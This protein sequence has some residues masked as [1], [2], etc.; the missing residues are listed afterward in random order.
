[1]TILG[2]QTR[3]GDLGQNP[4]LRAAAGDGAAAAPGGHRDEP[5][6]GR[7]AAGVVDVHPLPHRDRPE[8]PPARERSDPSG[9]VRRDRDR[10]GRA[11]P[12][13]P[14]G[15]PARL[16]A[17]PSAMRC[18]TRTRSTSAWKP[19]P[20][21]SATSSAASYP[22][23]CRPRTTSARRSGTGRSSWTPMGSNAWLKSAWPGRRS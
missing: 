16:V 11:D 17:L 14:G 13:D 10:T 9:T 22:A 20:P 2:C 15:S 18:R 21:P 7:A 1:M 3:R 4:T 8:P 6:G 19:E 5:R 23:C 12:A